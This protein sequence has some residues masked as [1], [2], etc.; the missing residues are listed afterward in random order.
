MLQYGKHPESGQQMEALVSRVNF[1]QSEHNPH[2]TFYEHM[3]GH[4]PSEQ[5]M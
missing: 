3:I 2:A 1:S 4:M 5:W